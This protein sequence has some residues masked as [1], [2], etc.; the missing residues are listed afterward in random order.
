MKSERRDGFNG[1]ESVTLDVF[2]I[3][4]TTIRFLVPHNLLPR[5]AEHPAY[6]LLERVKQD[7]TGCDYKATKKDADQRGQVR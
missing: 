3:D 5:R 2:S 7:G 4:V 1:A 6:L